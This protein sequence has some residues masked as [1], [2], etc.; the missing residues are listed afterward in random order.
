[1]SNYQHRRNLTNNIQWGLGILIYKVIKLE[2]GGKWFEPVLN[3][4]ITLSTIHMHIILFA[5]FQLGRQKNTTGRKILGGNMSPLPP[6]RCS[7]DKIRKH[8]NK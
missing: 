2:R 1:M 7:F 8:V 3:I 6:K 5:P 4:H